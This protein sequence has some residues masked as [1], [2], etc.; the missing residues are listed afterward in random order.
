MDR[1]KAKEKLI[2]SSRTIDPYIKL[3]KAR[4]KLVD[5]DEILRYYP[6]ADKIE[7]LN[8]DGH[9][10]LYTIVIPGEEIA[11]GLA[12]SGVGF[13]DFEV[14]APAGEFE[15]VIT[16]ILGFLRHCFARQIGPLAGE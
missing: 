1:D 5:V 4:Y 12:V 8:P 16:E 10:E 6:Q 9:P 14:I 15:T 2:Y 13:V 11:L 3:I 7:S